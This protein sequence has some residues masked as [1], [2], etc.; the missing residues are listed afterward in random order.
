[1]N[2][3]ALDIPEAFKDKITELAIVPMH[4]S[5]ACLRF[6]LTNDEVCLQAIPTWALDQYQIDPKRVEN[7]LHRYFNRRG[8][9]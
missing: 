2:E 7:A 9:L 8:L 1:M 6:T 5:G 4:V 3:Q